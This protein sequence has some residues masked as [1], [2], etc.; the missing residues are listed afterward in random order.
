MSS[1]DRAGALPS[2]QT[3]ALPVVLQ[4][5]VAL[6]FIGHGIYG[7]LTKAAW[8]PYFAVVGIDETT[9]WSLM[10]WVGVMD[11]AIGFLVF[12]WPCRALFAWAAAWAV[13][14]AMLRPLAPVRAGRSFSSAAATTACRSLFSLR[15]VCPAPGGIACPHS[16]PS[17]RARRVRLEGCLRLFTATLLGPAT[18]AARC[19]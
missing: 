6:C 15:W 8:L 1:A 18:P 9:A 3:L 11:I 2:G 14:T 13:W 10:R 16:G 5:G 17:R 12:A 19:C 4:T 7:I